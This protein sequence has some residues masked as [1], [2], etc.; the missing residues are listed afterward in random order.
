MNKEAIQNIRWKDKITAIAWMLFFISLPLGRPF[1]GITFGLLALVLIA[2]CRSLN[3]PLQFPGIAALPLLL[4]YAFHLIG[5]IYTDDYVFA[6]TDLQVKLPLAVLPLLFLITQRSSLVKRH[7][8]SA[9]VLSTLMVNFALLLLAVYRY[10]NGNEQAFF[11][12][13]YSPSMLPAY[14]AFIN[15]SALLFIMDPSWNIHL[16]RPVVRGS[17]VLVLSLS[18]VLLASKAGWLS[19]ALVYATSG[20]K[21]YF[22]KNRILAHSMAILSVAGLILLLTVTPAFQ[23]INQLIESLK[24][25]QTISSHQE[26]TANRL[27]AWQTAWHIAMDFFPMGTGTGDIKNIT[28]EYY[29]KAGYHWPLYYRLNAHNQFLQ[30]LATLGIGGLL[31]LIGFCLV[32]FFLRNKKTFGHM[33]FLAL[34]FI[35]LMSESM[36]EVQNGVMTVAGLYACWFLMD[37]SE[38]KKG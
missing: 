33:I 10:Y 7:L 19:L 35:N 12:T 28:L 24:H 6:R 3:F 4:F 1:T 16:W 37:E 17:A 18:V 31:S 26:S 20:F 15:V 11:Y 32:P 29:E 27:L 14:M 30:T 23:R 38:S 2:T 13:H 22:H 36:L 9:F 8:A 5:L 34:L 25:Y 21:L